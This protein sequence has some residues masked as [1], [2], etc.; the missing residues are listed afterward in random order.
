MLG[1]AAEEREKHAPAARAMR[2]HNLRPGKAFGASKTNTTSELL[3]T[4]VVEKGIAISFL[5]ETVFAKLA[6]ETDCEA[7]PN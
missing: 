1:G 3:R 5:G 4:L 2:N 7:S 6:S